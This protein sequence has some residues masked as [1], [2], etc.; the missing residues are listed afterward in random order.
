M[1]IT[2]DMHAHYLFCSWYVPNRGSG[3]GEW[4]N[5]VYNRVE[6]AF[7]INEYFLSIVYQS[8][9]S[10]WAART[11]VSMRSDERQN[12]YVRLFAYN[13][14]GHVGSIN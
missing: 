13:F 5:T 7:G 14:H 6:I 12:K 10:V 11:Y 2:A 1:E 9:F 8:V 3:G 4:K